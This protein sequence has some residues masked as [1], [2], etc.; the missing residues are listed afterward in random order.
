MP[1]IGE[2]KNNKLGDN[3]NKEDYNEY[4]LIEDDTFLSCE[5]VRI[6]INGGADPNVHSKTIHINA[7]DRGA[8]RTP[9]IDGYTKTFYVNG[10]QKI[11]TF[12]NFNGNNDCS[13]LEKQYIYD[14]SMVV[15]G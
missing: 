11:E 6:W 14:G 15:N 5:K 2:T 9:H 1:H 10:T 4:V 13:W 7:F 12:N 3:F 8:L